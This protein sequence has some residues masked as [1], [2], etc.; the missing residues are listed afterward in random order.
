MLKRTT[1]IISKAAAAVGLLLLPATGCH[2]PKAPAPAAAAAPAAATPP[3]VRYDQTYDP[4]IKEIMELARER[5]WEEAQTKA[6]ELMEK[7]P[8][9]PMARRV[10]NWVSEARQKRREQALEDKIREIDA[11]DSVFNPSIRS[12]ATEQKDRGLMARKDV[13][14][15]L[16]K[17]ENS[18]YIPESYGKTIH[19]KGPLFDFEST[20]GRMS[21]VLEKD[22]SVHIDNVPLGTLLV[23]LSQST[24]VNIIADKSL[25]VLT[26]LLTVNIGGQTNLNNV[27]LGEFFRY[28]A[29]N[30]GLQFQVGDE[31]VWVVDARNT[32]NIMQ[33]TRFYRLSKGFVLPAEFGPEEVSKV[34]VT[35]APNVSST[36]ESQ[37]FKR[38]VNDLTPKEPALEK[39][40]KELFT[41]KYS[42]DY[43]RNMVVATGTAEQ[44][45]VMERIIREFDR[46]IQQVL[47]E[48]R[49][50]TLSKPAFLQLG[51]LWETGRDPNAQTAPTDFTGLVGDL[52]FPHFITG[53]PAMGLGVNQVFTNVLNSA[54]L[55]ATITALQQTGEAQTLSEPRLTV[56]NNRPATIS[57]GKVQYYYEQYAVK[58]TVQQYYT[59]SSFVPEG[60]PTKITAGAELNVLASISG[61]GKSIL[62][63]LNPK[64]NTDV[65]LVKYATLTDYQGGTSNVV[66]SFDIKLPQYRTQELSTRVVINSGD[67]V[68]MGG[69]LERQ[70]STIVESVPVLGDLPILGPLFRRRTE[71]DQP[72]YLLIFVTATI[73]KESGEFLVYDNEP[74]DTKPGSP[75][76]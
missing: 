7:A 47:I 74:R 17:I 2:T 59:A 41:G 45:E 24:G 30:Y 34:T 32:N 43:E 15:A 51:V 61:N 29:R 57:D 48:A 12:L 26:N 68:V 22:V 56:L 16:D 63:A 11:K 5:R 9:D 18:P 3:K 54:Q 19:T 27:K 28:V 60:K 65:Q 40:I 10:A 50:V 72:R 31:L 62:L 35:T 55:S 39:A 73:L 6:D 4:E 33:E 21:K 52:T 49:F 67:T 71:L 69:V 58:Q 1:P 76:K 14:D 20:K 66:S 25:A 75:A 37:K 13:R 44:L 64:V 36:T 23:N 42:I 70:R 46:P 38:F 53:N 8:Q